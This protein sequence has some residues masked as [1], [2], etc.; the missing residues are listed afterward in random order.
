MIDDF[1]YM[2][3]IFQKL[4]ENSFV[5]RYKVITTLIGNKM[6]RGKE[7]GGEKEESDKLLHTIS[8]LFS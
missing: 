2:E 4:N 1:I 6:G 8:L 5:G 3:A 7:K